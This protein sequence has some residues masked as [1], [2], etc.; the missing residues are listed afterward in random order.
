MKE[1][2]GIAGLVES[3]G[4]SPLAGALQSGAMQ[5]AAAAN[6]AVGKI[7]PTV[8]NNHVTVVNGPNQTNIVTQGQH[9]SIVRKAISVQSQDEHIQHTAKTAV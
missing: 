9:A 7:A 3:A 5:L 8:Q 1:L 6:P 4:S 2:P